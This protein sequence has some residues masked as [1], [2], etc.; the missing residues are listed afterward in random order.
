MNNCKVALIS[1][2]TNDNSFYINLG[3]VYDKNIRQSIDKLNEIN[4]NT[5]YLCNF[6]A[7]IK[8]SNVTLDNIEEIKEFQTTFKL[9]P[10]I[11]SSKYINEETNIEFL[12][13]KL[14]DISCMVPLFSEPITRVIYKQN[15]SKNYKYF[16][17]LS[18]TEPVIRGSI[19]ENCLKST[20]ENENALFLTIGNYKGENKETTCNLN[21][22]YL[23]SVGVPEENI[24]I[25]EGYDSIIDDVIESLYILNMIYIIDT[26]Y[27]GVSR[28]DIGFLL[29]LIRFARAKNLIY[30]KIYFITN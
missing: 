28:N 24:I 8:G 13:P 21:K 23:I 2:S 17:I 10:I 7:T 5:Q 22:R 3:E 15:D 4:I 1:F 20:F 29:K 6:T 25:N 9:T 11:C 19:I 30:N 26:V 16:I 18:Y 27:I 12:A 14:Y